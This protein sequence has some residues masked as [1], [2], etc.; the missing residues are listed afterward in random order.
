MFGFAIR[1]KK[2]KWLLGNR[3]RSITE[4]RRTKRIAVLYEDGDYI[5]LPSWWVMCLTVKRFLKYIEKGQ[6]FMVEKNPYR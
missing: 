2:N 5:V 1:T 3:I 4:I 6:L